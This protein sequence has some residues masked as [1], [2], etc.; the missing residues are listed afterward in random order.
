MKKM[1]LLLLIF[2]SLVGCGKKDIQSDISEISKV[3]Y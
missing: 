3:G 1:V 2:F